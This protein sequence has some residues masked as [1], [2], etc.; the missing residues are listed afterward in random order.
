MRIVDTCTLLNLY[1]GWSGLLELADFEGSWCVAQSVFQ[2]SEYVREFDSSG[3][4]ILVPLD[5]KSPVESGLLSKLAV[6]SEQELQ[7]YVDFATELDD[8]EAESMAL[9]KN[10]DLVLV[11]DDRKAIR[12]AGRLDAPVEIL[13]TPAV[14][15]EWAQCNREPSDRVGQVIGRIHHLARYQ[16]P[17]D[18]PDQSWW[19]SW[20]DN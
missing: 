3:N 8:G 4:I 5:M 18:S 6:E 9:A 10:R 19:S 20:F 7:D 15:R 16:P 12:M 11:T 1:T 2:E 13:T 17:S 14:L